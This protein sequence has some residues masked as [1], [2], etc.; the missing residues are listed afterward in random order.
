MEDAP[1]PPKFEQVVRS[2][3][4]WMSADDTLMPDLELADK[5]LDSLETVSMLLDLEEQFGIRFP[6]ELLTSTS[7]ETPLS[8]WQMV[9]GLTTNSP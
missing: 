2:H 7:F 5:G 3:L 8:T 4:P 6:D 1:W 9:D